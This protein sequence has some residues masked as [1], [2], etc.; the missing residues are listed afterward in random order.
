MTGSKL[1]PLELGNY[2][3]AALGKE[4]DFRQFAR[5]HTQDTVFY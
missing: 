1:V 5:H 4:P 3:W 2:L